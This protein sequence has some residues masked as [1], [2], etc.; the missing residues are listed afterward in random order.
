MITYYIYILYSE[1]FDKFYIGYT[2]NVKMRLEHHNK[3][4][5][6]TF[7]AKYRPWTLKAVYKV[8]N[9]RGEALKLERF[10]KKQKSRKLL[11][12]LIQTDFQPTGKLAQLIRVPK[13]TIRD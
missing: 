2:T 11:L 3:D 6:N 9:D 1:K 10:I 8:G 7:T 13:G 12:Q 5:K 4:D